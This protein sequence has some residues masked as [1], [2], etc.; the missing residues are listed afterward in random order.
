MNAYPGNPAW[1]RAPLLGHN[2]VRLLYLDEAGSDRGAST[3]IVAGVLVHGDRDWPEINRRMDRVI[4]KYVPPADRGDFIF[5]AKDVF[6]GAGY[7][8]RTKPEWAN[9]DRRLNLMSDFADIIDELHIPIVAGGYK[10]HGF[11]SGISEIA[12]ALPD[13]KENLIHNMAA[14][15]CM[16]WADRWLEHFAPSEMATVVHEDGT[17]AKRLIKNSVL[18]ARNEHLLDRWG[19]SVEARQEVGLPLNRIIDTV[20]FVDK[21]GARLLQLAD[22]CAFTLGRV[23][24]DHGVQEHVFNVIWRHLEWMPKLQAKTAGVTGAMARTLSSPDG[25]QPA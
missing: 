8:N 12:E 2:L 22:L 19:L 9:R 18:L 16:I 24:K 1:E 10:K 13:H 5:H 4:E 3:L 25:G 21:Q 14:M 11:G 23:A 20:H 17:K 7:F 6:H 15:D